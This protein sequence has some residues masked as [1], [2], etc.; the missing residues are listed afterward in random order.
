[1]KKLTLLFLLCVLFSTFSFAF[2][3]QGNWR[4]RNNNGSE[5]SATW[6]TKQNQ[7]IVINSIDSIYR[8]RIQVQNNTGSDKSLNTNLMYASSPDG[9]WRYITNFVGN[10][11]F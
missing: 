10:N 4:W 5:T 1:M 8:L 11:A 6:R 7:R 3:S 9:P 2:I